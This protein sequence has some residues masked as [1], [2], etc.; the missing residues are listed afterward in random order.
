MQ[1]RDQ[2]DQ[3]ATVRADLLE[4]ACTILTGRF[5]DIF[6]TI[7]QY[8]CLLLFQVFQILDQGHFDL[9]FFDAGAFHFCVVDVQ[10]FIEVED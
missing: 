2:I 3:H 10:S 6:Y 4:F 7:S 9:I 5:C 1:S 8:E